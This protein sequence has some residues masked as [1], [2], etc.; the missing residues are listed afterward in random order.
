MKGVNELKDVSPQLEQFNTYLQE[1]GSSE[2]TRSSYMRDLRQLADFLDSVALEEA[3]SEG[4][5][6]FLDVQKANGRSASTL[7]RNVASIKNFYGYLMKC[8]VITDNPATALVSQRG[9]T[10]LPQVLSGAEVELLLDQPSCTDLKGYRDKAMLEVLYSTG[11]R[12]SELI[13]LHVSDV[14]LKTGTLCCTSRNKQRS[15]PLHHAAMKA[16]AEYISFIRDQMVRDPR[17][18]TLFVNVNGDPMS[19]QGFWKLIKTYQVKAGIEKNITPHTLRH[20]F[21][22]HHLEKGTDMR[23]VQEMMGHSDV[24]TTHIYSHILNQV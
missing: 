24:S 18:D 7:A 23:A 21:A 14:D 4:R 8:G 6:G 10:K 11:I 1:K 17:D 16:L 3:T 15:I 13:S 12:V 2:N 20:S 5:Q 19:R 9:E 22:A